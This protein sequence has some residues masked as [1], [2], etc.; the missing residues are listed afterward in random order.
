MDAVITFFSSQQVFKAE[1]VLKNNGISI[2][3]IPGPRE[4]SPN[5]GVAICFEYENKKELISLFD[6]NNIM[7]EKIYYYPKIKKLSNWLDN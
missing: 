1:K 4:I 5:C 3:I 7:Y 2:E 6:R